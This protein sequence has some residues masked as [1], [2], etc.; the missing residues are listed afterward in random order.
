MFYKE[1]TKRFH[2]SSIAR[3]EFVVG[4]QVLLYNCRLG[5][6]SLSV[7]VSFLL[8]CVMFFFSVWDT[9]FTFGG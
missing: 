8:I 3:K 7:V 1:K 6:I 2:D 5:L 4:Q 9:H